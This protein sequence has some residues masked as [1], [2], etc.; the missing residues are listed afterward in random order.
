MAY[1]AMSRAIAPSRRRT[2]CGSLTSYVCPRHRIV[3]GRRVRRRPAV[4]THGTAIAATAVRH[5][6]TFQA[7]ATVGAA[8]ERARRRKKAFATETGGGAKKIA[9][10]VESGSPQVTASGRQGVRNKIATS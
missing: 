4:I 9:G 2:C 8:E 7:P 1:E 5:A 10:G 3:V 6:G